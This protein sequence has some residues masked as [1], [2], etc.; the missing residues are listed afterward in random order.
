MYPH[1]CAYIIKGGGFSVYTPLPSWQ[2]KQ[3]TAY[4]NSKVPLPPSSYYNCSNR[5]YPDVSALGHNY[6][7][8]WGGM[9][10]QVDGYA[11]L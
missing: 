6:I 10:I 7:I 9:P 8:F 4:L 5:A 11:N 1:F 3:V 2:A